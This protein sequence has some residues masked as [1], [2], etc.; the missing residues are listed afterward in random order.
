M[1]PA[2]LRRDLTSGDTAALGGMDFS[3][4]DGGARPAS[5]AASARRTPPPFPAGTGQAQTFD[6]TPPKELGPKAEDAEIERLRKLVKQQEAEKAAAQ[7]LSS[8]LLS[9][10][11]SGQATPV[12]TI[13]HAAVM[14][15][16][17]ELI[18]EVLKR[19]SA[20][21]LQSTINVD[22]RVQWPKLTDDTGGGREVEEFYEKF[23]G[24]KA[25]FETH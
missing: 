6:L 12:T 17:T 19:N 10:N 21:R 13:D 1:D 4:Q 7:L 16:Q 15:K 11:P 24:S 5:T 9:G 20:P 25:L 18:A 3:L 14:D 22:P 2:R 8:Q 23:E